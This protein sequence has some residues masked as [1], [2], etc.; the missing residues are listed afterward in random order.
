MSLRRKDRNPNSQCRETFPEGCIWRSRDKRT[1]TMSTTRVR[2]KRAWKAAAPT[3][4]DRCA[5]RQGVEA[6]RSMPPLGSKCTY[7]CRCSLADALMGINVVDEVRSD[8]S[9]NV[10]AVL[11]QRSKALVEGWVGECVWRLRFAFFFFIS[12]AFDASKCSLSLM[13]YGGRKKRRQERKGRERSSPRRY[14]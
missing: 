14:R 8:G 13:A 9:G 7:P 6:R 12:D 10:V 5:Q 1:A 11:R 2:C 4:S 3:V